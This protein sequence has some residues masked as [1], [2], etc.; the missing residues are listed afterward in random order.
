MSE[1]TPRIVT[2]A[3]G[4][5][6]PDVWTLDDGRQLVDR[7]MV[8][9]LEVALRDQRDH[10][11]V[12]RRQR[13]ERPPWA[14]A[15]AVITLALALEHQFAPLRV[16][17]AL[18]HLVLAVCLLTAGPWRVLVELLGFVG[19]LVVYGMAALVCLLVV[20]ALALWWDR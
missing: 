11:H 4:R 18:A 5:G 20:A 3:R 2:Y 10:N 12:L 6:L 8:Q 1:D 15:R 17:L 16:L 14:W 7:S 9:R 19:A 13:D